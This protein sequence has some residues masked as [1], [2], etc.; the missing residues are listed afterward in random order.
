M[1]Q[2][3][4][5]AKSISGDG[6]QTIGNSICLTNTRSRNPLQ[7][8]TSRREELAIAATEAGGKNSASEVEIPGDIEFF[9]GVGGTNTKVARSSNK[10]FDSWSFVESVGREI[11]D[12]GT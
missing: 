5:E 12:Q 9:G 4:A 6:G 3:S 10:V 1:S 7:A 11:G 8:G 2:S